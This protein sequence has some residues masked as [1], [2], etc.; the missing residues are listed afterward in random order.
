MA[1]ILETLV[2]GLATKASASDDIFVRGTL[3]KRTK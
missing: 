3:E 1:A 2:P